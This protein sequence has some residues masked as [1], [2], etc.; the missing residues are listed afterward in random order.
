MSIQLDR[1]NKL[2]FVTLGLLCFALGSDSAIITSPSARMKHLPNRTLWVW[3]RPENLAAINP[4]NTAI[5]WLDQTILVGPQIVGQ[6]RHQPM[7]YPSGVTRIA[8]VRIETRPG[9]K[10]DKAA[11]DRVVDLLLYS[12]AHPGIAALQVDFDA[13][14]SER[15][16]YTSVL[17]K[18]RER[19]P[20]SLPLSITALASWCSNDDWIGNLPIDEAVPMFFRMEPDRRRAPADLPEFRIREPKCM[21]SAGISTHEA[22]PKNLAGKRLYVFAD[23]GWRQDLSLLTDRELP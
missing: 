14:R 16:F 4:Q 23:R 17:E 6:V 1:W 22:W 11:E 12:A 8:V 2:A 3:E 20:Q 10:L 15:S 21:G 13:R 5:A 9:G 18:L 19:M 7:S